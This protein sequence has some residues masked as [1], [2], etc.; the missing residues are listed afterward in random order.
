MLSEKY[1]AGFLDSDGTICLQY[2][3]DGRRANLIMAFSQKTSQDRVLKMIQEV[4]GG[5]IRTVE[6]KGVSYSTLGIF[7]RAAISVL[8][9]IK[10]YLVI[11]RHYAN[12]CL[13]VIQ[14]RIPDVKA[15][16]AY[17]KEQRRVRSLP[18]PNNPSRKWLAGYI[19]GDGCFSHTKMTKR[20]KI[21]LLLH[22]AA[23]NYDTEGIEV[24]FKAFGG[25]IHDMCKGRVKQY[26]LNLNP[27]KAKE[28]ISL[29]GKYLVTKQDQAL[30]ILG[31]AEMGH[32][33]DGKSIKAILKQLKAHQHRL[34]E[35]GPNVKDLLSQVENKTEF[36]NKR[37]EIFGCRSCHTSEREHV[38]YG[39]CGK[40]YQ[41][42]RRE[43]IRLTGHA[44]VEPN[45]LVMA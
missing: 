26:I 24:I 8:S 16:K 44:I 21:G 36:W 20:G 41:V 13:D 31:C 5:K 30:F 10:K 2:H 33:R 19:D 3:G 45:Q 11:K 29:F 25:R 7:G 43:N 17:M 9:R 37:D 1:I 35:P 15:C 39:L 14:N 42:V 12:V 28:F 40:C 6:V 22:V 18:L 4:V 34:N 38:G 23:S 32:Y 27:S